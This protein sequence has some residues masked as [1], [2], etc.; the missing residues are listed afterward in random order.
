M[1][2]HFQPSRFARRQFLAQSTCGLGAMA[3]VLHQTAKLRTMAV[4]K[5]TGMRQ[6]RDA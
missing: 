6:R 5:N 3:L 1:S 4:G 2:D